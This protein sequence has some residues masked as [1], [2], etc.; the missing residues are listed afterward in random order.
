MRVCE[1]VV[2]STES[3]EVFGSAE[4]TGGNYSLFGVKVELSRARQNQYSE[5][6]IIHDTGNLNT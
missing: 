6:G 3:T 2:Q 1:M 4:C 5:Y